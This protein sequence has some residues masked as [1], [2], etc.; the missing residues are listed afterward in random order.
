MKILMLTPYLPYPL[1]SGG[2]I[3]TYNLLKNLKDKHEITL[4]AY[5]R[6]ESERKYV[7]ELEKYCK[8]VLVFKRRP[9]WNLRNIL[10]SAFSS[11][12][13]LVTIYLSRRFQEAIRR[14]LNETSYNLIHAETF[15]M[16]PNI[17]KTQVPIILVEQTIEYLA[18]QT[19]VWQTWLWPIKPF[20]YLDVWKIRR[21]ETAYWRT[22]NRLITMS[23]E[24]KRA[25]QLEVGS[26]VPIDVVANGVDIGFFSKTKKE[27]PKEPTVLFVGT[28]KWL[29]NIDAVEFLVEEI[30][31]QVLEKLSKAKLLIVGFSPSKKI[32]EY[33]KYPSITVRGDIEDI[34]LAYSQA[35]V[36]LAPIRSGKGT[37][38]KV[39]EAMATGTPI[40]ATSLAVEGIGVDPNSH[41]LVG[42]TAE[43]L[44][45][46]T[47]KA[48][49]DDR[50]RE[51][52]AKNSKALVEKKFNWATISY[53]L[54]RVY[55]EVG[56]TNRS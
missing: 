27:F 49:T 5:I 17:P 53:E 37:R 41:V 35:D 19:Y 11:Y 42:D 32:L 16:M 8:K 43:E 4:F 2:Q 28:F 47:V 31:P 9:A 54:D 20:L 24:D 10:G 6:R 14:E 55:S 45:S 22:A 46:L 51:T 13:F 40:V 25:I 7:K 50:L 18:Y 38:Y 30:W 12:P 34:R 23:N 3:R 1:L 56:K 52:L 26:G 33:G 15:Y 36:L 48:L 29:P 44:A 39:L 21:W